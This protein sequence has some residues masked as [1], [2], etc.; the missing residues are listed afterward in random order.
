[1][2][3]H[4]RPSLFI[5]LVI[6]RGVVDVRF[7]VREVL[8]DGEGRPETSACMRMSGFLAHLKKKVFFVTAYT[9]LLPKGALLSALVRFRSALNKTFT[10]R[11]LALLKKKTH[12]FS[13]LKIYSTYCFVTAEYYP[14]PVFTR[15]RVRNV[16]WMEEAQD[17]KL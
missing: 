1:M 12:T 14:S 7:P 15:C 8:S 13:L 6:S 17:C 4:C 9:S 3:D 5:F 2:S 11:G 10:E 16:E